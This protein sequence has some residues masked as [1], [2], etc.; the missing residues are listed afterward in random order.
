MCSDGQLSHSLFSPL[1]LEFRNARAAVVKDFLCCRSLVAYALFEVAP[2]PIPELTLHFI[3]D[4]CRMTTEKPDAALSLGKISEEINTNHELT[5]DTRSIP[6]SLMNRDH[7][8]SVP[9]P[10]DKPNP[11]A[12]CG[13]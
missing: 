2:K 5:D 10:S 13:L 3:A 1:F 4:C 8:R 9:S 12:M 7:S 11:E 6:I